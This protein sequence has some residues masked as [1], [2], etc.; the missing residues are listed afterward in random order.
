MK[1]IVKIFLIINLLFLIGFLGHFQIAAEDYFGVSVALEELSEKQRQ[2]MCTAACYKENWNCAV[3]SCYYDPTN[4]CNEYYQGECYCGGFGCGRAK[5][6]ALSG[7]EMLDCMVTS[8]EPDTAVDNFDKQIKQ[9]MEAILIYL[10][11]GNEQEAQ[12]ATR[13]LLNVVNS[14]LVYLLDKRSDLDNATKSM[15]KTT[16]NDLISNVRSQ[17]A[18]QGSKIDSCGFLWTRNCLYLDPVTSSDIIMHEF[19]HV[20]IENLTPGYQIPGI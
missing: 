8:V 4:S 17:K 10:G 2:C 1:K 11:K 18:G 14:K 7:G 9:H 3:V 6:S 12:A 5:I 19:S 20:I 13:E 16:V 15:I